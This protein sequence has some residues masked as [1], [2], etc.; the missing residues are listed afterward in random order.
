MSN[1]QCLLKYVFAR[2]AVTLLFVSCSSNADLPS[3][4]LYVIEADGNNRAI[5]L[6]DPEQRYWGPAWSPDGTK[7]VFSI[8]TRSGGELYIA[9]VDGSELTQLTNNGRSNYLPAWSPSGQVISFISQEST[10]TSTSEIYAIHADGSNEVRLTDNDDWEYGTSWSKDGTKI[11][12][13]SQRNGDWQIYTMDPDGNHQLPLPNPAHGNAPVWS[14]DGLRIAFTSDQDG[15]DDIWV[16]NADGS[17]QQN[18]TDNDV[19]DDQPQ[20]SPDGTQIAFTSDR[21]GTANIFVMN[22]DGSN[23][24]NLTHDVSLEEGIPVWSPDSNRLIFHAAIQTK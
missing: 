7:L 16:M 5:I 9:N 6:S 20:W 19:W 8:S 11:I 22:S 17:D 10:D 15:D 14:P 18:L 21:D 23:P 12:F 3:T 1:F 24:R 4:S 13:G 2:L